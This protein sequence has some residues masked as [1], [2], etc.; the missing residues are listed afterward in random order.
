MNICVIDTE[1]TGL[2]LSSDEVL[3]ISIIDASGED[4]M[5]SLVRPEHHE[6]WPEAQRIHGILP[7]DVAS[8]PTLAE[9]RPQIREIVAGRIVVIYNAEYDQAMLP[10]CLDTASDI[11]CCMWGFAQ[12]YAVLHDEVE[13]RHK[14][15]HAAH[16]VDHD[17]G[18]DAAHRAA[19]DAAATLSV[20]RWLS[21]Q[22]PINYPLEN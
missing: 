5:H 10:D 2:D 14:L 12:E 16:F 17:W 22:D 1:T 4:L 20:W 8:A 21:K 3:E 15:V 6:S 9:L 11:L 13:R 19:H 7:E 18:Q